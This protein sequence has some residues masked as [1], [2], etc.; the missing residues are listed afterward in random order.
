ML[1]KLTHMMTIFGISF[2]D[3]TVSD[4]REQAFRKQRAKDI[5]QNSE[6]MNLLKVELDLM[7]LKSKTEDEI[8]DLCTDEDRK[9]KLFKY[10]IKI[11][12]QDEQEYMFGNGTKLAVIRKREATKATLVP[13]KCPMLTTK[14]MFQIVD[15]YAEKCGAEKTDYKYIWKLCNPFLLIIRDTGGLPN[16]LQFMLNTCFNK[17]NKNGKAFFHNIKDQDFDKIF[18]ETTITLE[19]KYGIY[20]SVRE[21]KRLALEL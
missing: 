17:L 9:D 6:I 15:F 1:A 21:N 10:I 7:E 16:A 20:K 5:V 2:E 4:F 14:S 18:K 3:F 13:I 8:I 11:L 12:A 19:E